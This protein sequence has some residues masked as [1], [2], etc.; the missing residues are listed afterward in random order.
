[1]QSIIVDYIVF[2]LL[3]GLSF[4]VLIYSKLS[5]PKQQTKA[6]YVFASKGSV[7]MGAML[8]SI[9][10]GFLGVKVFL[11]KIALTIYIY[12]YAHNI[13]AIN[14]VKN[15]AIDLNFSGILLQLCPI[16]YNAE[17]GAYLF[18]SPLELAGFKL[19]QN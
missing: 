12:V 10:R 7:S 4:A 18:P 16:H 3:I 17:P 13:I 1:M 19:P 9:A 14:I 8:L 11:G 5:G 6:D 15:Y 2:L